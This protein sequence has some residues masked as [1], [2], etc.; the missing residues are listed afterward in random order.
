MREIIKY[1]NDLNRVKIPLLSE[2]EHNLFML[3]L[4]S[5]KDAIEKDD[6]NKDGLYIISLHLDTLKNFL[7]K[8]LTYR[9]F[10]KIVSTFKDKIFKSDF[11]MLVKEGDLIGTMYVHL[12][13]YFVV[14]HRS[15]N[16]F[17][18]FERIDIKISPYFSYLV[19]ELNA[20]FTRFELAEFLEIRGQYTKILYRLLKQFRNTGKM[21]T[22]SN[23]WNE[24]CEIMGISKDYLPHHIDQRV[25]RPAIKELSS[26][27][28]NPIFKNLTYKKIKDFKQKGKIVGIEFYFT[29]QKI[30]EEKP[31]KNKNRFVVTEKIY[32]DTG[33]EKAE[34]LRDKIKVSA[35]NK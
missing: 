14:W 35:A 34:Y 13:E 22:F 23:K 25:L 27:K 8:N 10:D 6:A 7:S 32:F 29:P 26:K 28:D 33:T 31:L 16:G 18:G 15:D 20:N 21:I 4:N 3:I 24:F 30:K 2:Q 19:D 1:H 11:K 5:I 9:E 17:T 12:F